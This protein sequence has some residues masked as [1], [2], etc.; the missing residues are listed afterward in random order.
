MNIALIFPGGT[1]Q[2][3]NSK[4]KPKQMDGNNVEGL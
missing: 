1:C 2:R 4:S 3:M